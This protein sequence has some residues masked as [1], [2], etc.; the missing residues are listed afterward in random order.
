MVFLESSKIVYNFYAKQVGSGSSSLEL[1]PH[2]SL[3]LEEEGL[4]RRS[5][6]S[7]LLKQVCDAYDRGKFPT[8]AVSTKAEP[9][10][11]H[12]VSLETFGDPHL[13]AV[14][15]KKYLRDLPQP[16]FPE[17]LYPVIYRCPTPNNDPG[18]MSAILYVRDV[19][20]PELPRCAYILLSH[21]LR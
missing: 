14:L 20:L 19:I 9:C 6:N 7:V 2:I 17:S 12:I 18:D 11:G 8:I 5:P 15:I 21:V 10:A 4:F 1:H 3:G 13:A 16:I